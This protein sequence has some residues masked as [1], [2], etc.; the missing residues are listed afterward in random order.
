MEWAIWRLRSWLGALALVCLTTPALA[1]S[2]TTVAGNGSYGICN[3]VGLATASPLRAP[4][5]LIIDSQGNKYFADKGAHQ[6]CKIDTSGNISVVAGTG[7]AGPDGDGG[8][9][10]QAQLNSPSSV[11]LDAAG[12]LYIADTS[13]QR[14]RKVA[15]SAG[16][17]NGNS[18]ITTVAGTLTRPAGPL[19]YNGD[20]QP[21]GSAWLNNPSGVAIDSEGNLY[22]ADRTNHRIRKVAVCNGTISGACEI[23]TV[24]G[25][26]NGISLGSFVDGGPAVGVNNLD[27]PLGVAVDREGNLYIADSYNF[28][29]RKVTKSTGLI[30]TV[31]GDGNITTLHPY[32]VALDNA[33]NLFIADYE[34]SLVRKTSTS[35]GTLTTVVGSSGAINTLP[36]L[37]QPAGV[38][39]DSAGDLYIAA[40]SSFRI[41][42][43]TFG[44]PGAPLN[45]V[46]TPGS[47]QASVTWNAPNSAGESAITGYTVISSPGNKTCAVASPFST[48]LTCDVTGLT[49]GMAYSFTVTA[50]NAQGTGPGGISSPVTILTT[51]GAP[52]IG[53]AVPGD[54]QVTVAFTAP[55]SD[56]GS[57][58]LS[59]TVT[60]N[61]DGKTCNLSS[62]FSTPLTC[63]VTGLTNGTAYTFTVTA[64]NALGL[65]HPS[66]PSNSAT[67]ALVPGA[68]GIGTV[69]PGNGQAS[70]T[71]TPPAS[72]GGSAVTSYTI[73]SIPDGLTCVVSVPATGCTI[74]GLTNDTTYSFTATATNIIGTGPASAPSNGIT[75][76]ANMKSFSG[77]APTGTG[78]VSV[79]ISSGGGASCGFERVQLVTASSQS[80]AP[81]RWVSFPHGLLDFVLAGCDTSEVT[82][83]LTYPAPLSDGVQYW[84]FRSGSWGPYAGGQVTGGS[85]SALLKLRDGGSGDDDGVVNGRIVD[86]GQVAVLDESLIPRIPTLSTWSLLGMS[87][88]LGLLGWRRRRAMT[89]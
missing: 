22:I 80:V 75:P 69:T 21:A 4:N 87:A 36:A 2:S 43:V 72:D 37:A 42:K 31:A 52:T 13:N 19:G 51:P 84:K 81:P 83:T 89:N 30:S 66:E 34:N 20:N 24:A 60:S 3:N 18:L 25:L 53:E 14:I 64:A 68:P 56:G 77:P 59:Y 23:T 79:S 38:T 5:G 48:P 11:A 46:A 41:F 67:P 55:A 33:G 76:L 7:T 10:S 70:I 74:A 17:I 49:G 39:V 57:P 32:G 12:N 26:G 47:G 15:A 29:V 58:I 1:A 73:S 85:T 65:G 6:V 16:T 27:G 28:R 35:G 78:T 62:P 61:P 44:Y 50:T 86:P 9:A 54:G 45:V 63:N 8:T 82:L 71:V 40:P 88:A